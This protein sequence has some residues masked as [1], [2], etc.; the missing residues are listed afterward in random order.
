VELR[1]VNCSPY[2]LRYQVKKKEFVWKNGT[3]R[4]EGMRIEDFDGET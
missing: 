4:R 1:D 2:Y 3:Y